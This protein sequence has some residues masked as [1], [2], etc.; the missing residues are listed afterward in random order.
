M[1]V[2]ADE[3]ELLPTTTAP[4]GPAS[5][6]TATLPLRLLLR[7]EEAAT[8]LGIGRSTIYDLLRTGALGSVRIGA[9]RRIPAEALHQF[10]ARLPGNVGSHIH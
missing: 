6:D 1:A 7:P 9:S 10:I 4:A 8:A 5:G 3:W 2:R